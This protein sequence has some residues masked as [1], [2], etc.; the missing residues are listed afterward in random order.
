LQK[1]DVKQIEK[2]RISFFGHDPCLSPSLTLSI[3]GGFPLIHIFAELCNT[4]THQPIELKNCSNLQQIREVFSFRLQI[5]FRFGFGVSMGDV[6]MGTC[7]CLLGQFCLA[8]GTN[9]ISHFWAEVFLDSRLS[10]KSLK[11]LI[12]LP[13]YLEPNLRL[14][15]GKF[16]V[17]QKVTLGIF[18]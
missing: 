7:F 16:Q 3:P 14:K 11:P 1:R 17:P 5:F 10:S 18:H 12:G 6:I 13:A 2:N 8:L 9:P 15:L 4:I